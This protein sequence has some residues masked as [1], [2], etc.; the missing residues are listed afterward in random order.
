M[1]IELYSV[2]DQTCLIPTIKT[3]YSRTL[4]G[5]YTIDLVWLKWG[6]TLMW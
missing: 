5:H 2:V 1:K 4:N 6:I 3:T